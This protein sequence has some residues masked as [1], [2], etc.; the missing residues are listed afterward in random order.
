MVATL[1]DA[2]SNRQESREKPGRRG[3]V[4]SLAYAGGIVGSFLIGQLSSSLGST[5]EATGSATRTETAVTVGPVDTC[6]HLGFPVEIPSDTSWKWG[7]W[8][9][10]V[11]KGLIKHDFMVVGV[12]LRTNDIDGAIELG[13]GNQGSEQVVAHLPSSWSAGTYGLLGIVYL[14]TPVRL[15]AGTRVAA[16]YTVGDTTPHDIH[17]KVLYQEILSG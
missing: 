15:K 7:S 2:I 12:H 14:P 17:V 8:A 1:S 13:T 11:P 9:E 5:S 3:F 4:K 6:P 16:R 10:I